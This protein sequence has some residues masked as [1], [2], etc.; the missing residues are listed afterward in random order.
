MILHGADVNGVSGGINTGDIANSV[1]FRAS[2]SAYLSRTFGTPTTQNTFTLSLWLKKSFLSPANETTLFSNAAGNE[3]LY[4]PAGAD[5][6]RLYVGGS[7]TSTAVFRDPISHYHVVLN[8]NGTT[9]KVF[10]NNAEVL[11]RTATPSSLNSAVGH[12]IGKNGSAPAAYLDGYLSRVC[13]VDGQALTPSS[14]IEFNST[15]NEWVSKSQSDVKAVV[16]AGGTNSFMLDFDDATSLTTLGYDLHGVRYDSPSMTSDGTGDYVTFPDS[17]GFD[18]GTGDFTI[19]GWFKISNT[20]NNYLFGRYGAGSG[21]GVLQQ[22]GA[23]WYWYYGN[24]ASHAI[25]NSFTPTIGQWYHIAVSRSGTTLRVFKDGTVLGSAT[26]SNN[27]DGTGL[28][29][30]FSTGNHLIAPNTT[31]GSVS[32]FRI[33][34]GTALYT[35]TFTPSTTPLT[36][37][38][39]TSLLT[40][41]NNPLVDN[42]GNGLSPTINGN[43]TYSTNN[44]FTTANDWTLSGISLTAGVTYD[45]MLDVPGN[46]YATLNPLQTSSS[47]TL[48]SGNL[49]GTVTGGLIYSCAGTQTVTADKWY[50]ETVRS[51]AF[52]AYPLVG[53][54]D[55]SQLDSA[56]VSSFTTSAGSG[57]TSGCITHGC[58]GFVSLSN[59]TGT[60][61]GVTY[62]TTDVLMVALD[63]TLGKV[64]FG[65]NG[66]WNNS[67]NPA[68]NTGGH[69]FSTLS[70]KGYCPIV[71]CNADT[72]NTW[73]CNFGQRPF[74]Y[75]PPTG[76][77]ALCQENLPTPV[78]AVT[79]SGSF[80]GNAAADGPF[81]WMKGVPKTLTIN[82]NAVT[83]G[84]HADKT[85]GGF[86]LRTASSSY[87][88]SGS[89]TW[90]AT[91]DSDIQNSFKYRNA[92]G[93]P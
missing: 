18:F 11:S 3:Y 28:Y 21:Y 10:V 48:S 33:V 72:T 86:K 47:I 35:T 7:T 79:V 89:N 55:F 74:A 49:N 92:Q 57:N 13:F 38:S 19:E 69:T 36:A 42:S 54:M 44:P 5:T 62:N 68:T 84:T 56:Y 53:F 1:R 29:G 41:Q 30:I 93:N 73:N 4:V 91:I 65:K 8:S 70:G 64:W 14:F 23:N 71:S 31:Y 52:G 32:N 61:D 81:V 9:M 43:P 2:N 59:N 40:F 51:A 16:D 60:T 22:Q 37:I 6:L 63:A 17:N 78:D 46:S 82:G 85:A 24:G 75:T 66:T 12:L 83:F 50:F 45:H 15:I 67:S 20:T 58:T 80:T 87:N 26:D 25:S 39:G 77:L 90:T 88:A 27:Y 34:K 76:F